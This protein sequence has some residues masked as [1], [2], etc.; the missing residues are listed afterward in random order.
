MLKKGVHIFLA[1][2]YVIL[3]F[4]VENNSPCFSGAIIFAMIEEHIY[5]ERI[6]LRGGFL[7][8]H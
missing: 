4:R 6:V 7:V 5:V 3:R 8:W 2:R 1:R